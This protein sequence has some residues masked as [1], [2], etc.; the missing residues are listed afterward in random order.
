MKHEIGIVMDPIGAIKIAK[1]SSFAMLL[2]AQ[3][4]G[5]RLQYLTLDDLSLRGQRAQLRHDP[6]LGAVWK[7]HDGAGREQL[8]AS[9]HQHQRTRPFLCR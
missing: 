9:Q 7:R 4:R 5:W 8:V 1:D 6:L 2:A 3:R